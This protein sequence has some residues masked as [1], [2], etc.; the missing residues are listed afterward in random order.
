[1]NRIYP[2][3]D[4]DEGYTVISAEERFEH[5][6]KTGVF[7]PKRRKLTQEELDHRHRE[8]MVLAKVII[9][10]L[11]LLALFILLFYLTAPLAILEPT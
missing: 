5:L 2:K 11:S 4:P 1:M 3:P 8:E 7:P 10:G 9:G 6:R